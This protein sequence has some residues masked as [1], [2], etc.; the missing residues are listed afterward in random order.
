MPTSLLLQVDQ[1]I[2]SA[3][4]L[5]RMSLFLALFGHAPISELRP[6]SG[7][8]RKL[9]FETPKGRFWRRVQLIA[10]THSANFSAGV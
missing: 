9:D 8:K 10:A 1:V 7:G 6:L 2:E 4:L 3:C 5:Q